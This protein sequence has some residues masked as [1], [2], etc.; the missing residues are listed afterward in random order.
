M[1]ELWLKRKL[2]RTWLVFCIDLGGTAE[3]QDLVS[4]Q[5]SVA[6]AMLLH[7]APSPYQADTPDLL[8]HV[9]PLR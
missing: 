7:D 3:A 2:V 5:T 1:V 4:L 6:A 8:E 9:D